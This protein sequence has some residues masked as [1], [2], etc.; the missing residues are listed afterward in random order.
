[1][2]CMH[3]FR[4]QGL[5]ESGCARNETRSDQVDLVVAMAVWRSQLPFFLHGFPFAKLDQDTVEGALSL[6]HLLL[7]HVGFRRVSSNVV[8]THGE[9]RGLVERASPSMLYGGWHF[10]RGEIRFNLVI[11]TILS[12]LLYQELLTATIH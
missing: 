6:F 5:R 1:M 9:V 3:N 12:L 10:V 8:V 7:I 2:Q 4:S 11:T